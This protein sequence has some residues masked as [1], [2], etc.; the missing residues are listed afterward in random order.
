MEVDGIN[1]D[2]SQPMDADGS[3]AP[4]P[5]PDTGIIEAIY[6]PSNFSWVFDASTPTWLLC[7]I[8][9]AKYMALAQSCTCFTREG[10]GVSVTDSVVDISNFTDGEFATV[11]CQEPENRE[12]SKVCCPSCSQWV[13]VFCRCAANPRLHVQ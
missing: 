3:I 9:C 4:W 8:G 10:A 2:G 7:C 1:H 11:Q 6:K 5:Y 12:W 13:Y